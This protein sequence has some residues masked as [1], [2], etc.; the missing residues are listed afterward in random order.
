MEDPEQAFIEYASL[1]T[2]EARDPQRSTH[3]HGSINTITIH[4][5]QQ[6]DPHDDELEG[7]KEEEKISW[8]DININRDS[9]AVEEE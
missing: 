8:E 9:K 4:P 5:K 7:N 1:R 2:D 6:S 3:I